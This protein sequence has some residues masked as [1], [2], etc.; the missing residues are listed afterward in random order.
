MMLKEL[1]LLSCGVLS[2]LGATIPAKDRI[3]IPLTDDQLIFP[4][5]A[6]D[7]INRQSFDFFW[8]AFVCLW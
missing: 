4:D 7:C 1:M 2:V 3:N 5:N 6:D 8:C